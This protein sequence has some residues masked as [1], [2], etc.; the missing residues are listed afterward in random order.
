M[1][2]AVVSLAAVDPDGGPDSGV[3]AS[4]ADGGAAVSSAEQAGQHQGLSQQIAPRQ[5]L[6]VGPAFQPGPGL[7]SGAGKISDCSALATFSAA[8]R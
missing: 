4:T 2:G 3:A 5:D 6:D 8:V 1:A 7:Y